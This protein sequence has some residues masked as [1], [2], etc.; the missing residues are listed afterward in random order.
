MVEINNAPW[1]VAADVCKALGLTQ[2]AQSKA[3]SNMNSN[4]VR[5]QR[6]DGGKHGRPNKLVSEAGVYGLIMQSRKPEAKAFQDWVTG[7]VLPAIR[8]DGGYIKGEE[9]VATGD[10]WMQSTPLAV[11]TFTCGGEC[12]RTMSHSSGSHGRLA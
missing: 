5:Q 4:H 12:S 7:T 6:V 9:K 3:I 10:S 2:T 11:A 8:K 1:F